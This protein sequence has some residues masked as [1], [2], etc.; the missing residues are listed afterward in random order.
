M[1]VTTEQSWSAQGVTLGR[2]LHSL[3]LAPG[4]STKVAVVDWQRSTKATGTETA[5]ENEAL[6]GTT[7]QNRS[8]SEVAN[9]IAIE[10]QHGSSQAFQHGN[11]SGSG[12]SIGVSLFGMGGGGNWGKSSNT[13]FATAVSRSTGVKSVATDATQR[14]SARTQ[15]L[16]TAAR[17]RNM[18]V[19]RETT[20]TEKDQV[21]TRVVTNYNHMHAMSV[22]YYEVVQVYNVT[23]KP[24]K[25]ERC[26]FIPL[27]ELT[28][29]RRH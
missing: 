22:Q 13:G 25:L 17:S 5:A 3:A 11:S 10:E 26:L 19:V 29:P 9:A 20:Q 23:T 7:D 18:T 6:A 28:L 12:G 14:I 27:Q 24:T 21:V 1:V 16:A 2:L 4:E 8:I 15:Q